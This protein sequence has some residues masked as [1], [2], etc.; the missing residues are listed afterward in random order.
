MPNIATDSYI[1]VLPLSLL[2]FYFLI[3]SSFRIFLYFI[4]D[5]L[6]FFFGISFHHRS[7]ALLRLGGFDLYFLTRVV[8]RDLMAHNCA[9][10]SF[11]RISLVFD[12]LFMISLSVLGSDCLSFLNLSLSLSSGLTS[13]PF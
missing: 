13:A 2:V 3:M 12:C 5:I 10:D 6:S 7:R 8:P 1:L 9:D 11:D 4:G